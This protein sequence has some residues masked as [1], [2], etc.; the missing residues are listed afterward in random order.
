[1]GPL[2]RFLRGLSQAGIKPRAVREWQRVLEQRAR[3]L[4]A[5][6]TDD[7]FRQQAGLEPRDQ[8]LRRQFLEI[9]KGG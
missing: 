4:E 9:L 7:L 6:E 1:M 3:L 8:A 2:T 5:K